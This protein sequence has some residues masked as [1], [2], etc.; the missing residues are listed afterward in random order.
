MSLKFKEFVPG[1][2]G[3]FLIFILISYF[4]KI[5]FGGMDGGVLI[6]GGWQYHLGYTPYKDFVTLVPPG[7][8]LG[9]KLAFDWFGVNWNSIVLFT[10][11]F[12]AAAFIVQFYI[13]RKLGISLFLSFLTVFLI[14]IVSTIQLSFWWYNQITA[15]IAAIYLS[16][17]I[18]FVQQPEKKISKILLFSSTFIFL[19]MK[20]NTAAPL[21]AGSSI[22]YLLFGSH[23]KTFITVQAAGFFVFIIGSILFN[24]DILHLVAIYLKAG[25]RLTDSGL[26]WD[27]FFR[28]YRFEAVITFKYLLALLV[29]LFAAGYIIVDSGKTIRS[30][31]KIDKKILL[32]CSLGMLVSFFA[33]ATNN[34]FNMVD[35]PLFLVAFVIALKQFSP[36]I[37]RTFQQF[38]HL[39]VIFVFFGFIFIASRY[40]KT[41]LRIKVI[42]PN[43]YYQDLELKKLSV[44]KFFEGMRASPNLIKT[45]K[46]MDE[47]I[48]PLKKSGILDE[49]IY[50]GSRIDF[51]Y[52]MYRIKPA[53]RLPLW[54]GENARAGGL[55][56]GT[57][58]GMIENF[59]K[60]PFTAILFYK[61]NYPFFPVELLNYMKTSFRMCDYENI[62]AWFEKKGYE[63]LCPS[64]RRLK[65]PELTL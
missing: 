57:E 1:F 55:P 48:L 22:L 58:K 46:N 41:R 38:F 21:I 9:T 14:H 5:Q 61:G 49:K 16:S 37:P 29:I 43:L 25:G 65:L 47:V 63:R 12:S 6:N 50:F 59:K 35:A 44:P 36:F 7:L 32:M 28:I 26:M 15:V 33:M 42:G 51:A 10:A 3:A 18:L 4:G 45:I 39:A 19:F 23:R 56:K 20:V 53:P 17:V 62:E 13:L 30:I 60:T 11:A 31:R 24:I 54:W 34:D 2:F 64:N 8:F 52:A 27:F 40:T